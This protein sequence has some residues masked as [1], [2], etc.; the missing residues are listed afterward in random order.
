MLLLFPGHLRDRPQPGRTDRP[1]ARPEGLHG[2]GRGRDAPDSADCG[3]T[4]RAG[5]PSHQQRAGRRQEPAGAGREGRGAGKVQGRRGVSQL[6][7]FVVDSFCVFFV[8]FSWRRRTNFKMRFFYLSPPEFD[9]G[10]G[11]AIIFY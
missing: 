3:A 5:H 8:W 9:R 10:V 7:C 2:G 11:T 1:R 6:G 4:D